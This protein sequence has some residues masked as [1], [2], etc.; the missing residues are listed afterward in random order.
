M[1]RR[2]AALALCSCVVVLAGCDDPYSD[3]RGGAPPSEPTAVAATPAPPPAAA[4]APIRTPS[5]SDRADQPGTTA[6][7][8][9]RDFAH[10]WSN[11]SWR[12][13]APQQQ[14]A[15]MATGHLRDYLL[16]QDLAPLDPGT[17]E[18]TRPSWTG[19]I[20]AVSFKSTTGARR[21]AV[22]VVREQEYSNGQPKPAGL[23]YTVY[24]AEVTRVDGGWAVSKWEGQP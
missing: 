13:P 1:V 12:D 23:S 4:P 5:P 18:R 3:V 11:W 19:R 2:A 16:E 15:Q 10:R 24:L 7:A 14:L 20:E 21:A 8:V 22:V 9:L 6:E 17:L